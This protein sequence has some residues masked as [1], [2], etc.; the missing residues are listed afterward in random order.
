MIEK[1]LQEIANND[2]TVSINF[3]IE[4]T[5]RIETVQFFKQQ[6]EKYNCANRVIIELTE[7]EGIEN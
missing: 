2:M 6:I 3:T 1:S 4:D 7:S 5:Q